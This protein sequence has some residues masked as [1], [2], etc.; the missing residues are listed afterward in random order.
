[1]KESFVTRY[2]E[3]EEWMQHTDRGNRGS[4]EVE[5]EWIYI[6]KKPKGVVN[7]TRTFNHR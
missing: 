5:C 4:T 2:F 3:K 7:Q 6:P 1:M